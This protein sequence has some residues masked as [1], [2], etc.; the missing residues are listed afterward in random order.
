MCKDS[1]GAWDVAWDT[2]E[3]TIGLQEHRVRDD[4]Q[5]RLYGVHPHTIF[6]IYVKTLEVQKSSEGKTTD[7]DTGES[8]GGKEGQSPEVKDRF[9]HLQNRQIDI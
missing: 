9:K 5:R 3:E 8:E 1:P 4:D 7:T 2:I 6:N